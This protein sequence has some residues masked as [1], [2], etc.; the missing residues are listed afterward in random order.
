MGTQYGGVK[1]RERPVAEAEDRA[2]V[3]SAYGP[4]L[5][6]E[7]GRPVG[8]QLAHVLGGGKCSLAYCSH[9]YTRHERLCISETCLLHDTVG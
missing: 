3:H 2:H 9:A 7:Q 4:S 6:A 1:L 8:K 5:F